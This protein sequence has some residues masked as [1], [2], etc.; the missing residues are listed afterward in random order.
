MQH[1]Y[2]PF[3]FT[4]MIF[5]LVAVAVIRQAVSPIRMGPIPRFL[6]WT[7]SRQASSGVTQVWFTYCKWICFAME[8]K[9]VHRSPEAPL[10]QVH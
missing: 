4:E 9:D 3:H 5:P 10:K 7:M 2:I 6:S 8:A 1:P